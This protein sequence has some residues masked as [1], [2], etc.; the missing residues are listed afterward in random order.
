ML[1]TNFGN[2]R[3][4][5][6]ISIAGFNLLC[7]CNSVEA[8]IVG[9]RHTNT[10]IKVKDDISQIIGGRQAGNNLF[11]S[12][13]QFSVNSGTAASFEHG[14]DIDNIFSRVTGGNISQID[15]LIQTQG[16]ANLFLINPAG[17]IFGANARLDVGGSFIATTAERAIFE[18]GTK[19]SAATAENQPIL[20]ISSPIGLQYGRAAAVTVMPNADRGM[21][22]KNAGLSIQSGNTLGLLGGDV[23]I[24]RNSLNAIAGNIEIGSIKSGTVT[25]EPSVRGWNFNYDKVSE[26]GRINLSNRAFVNS[27]GVVN[28]RGKTIDF[29]SSSGISNFTDTSGGDGIVKLNAVRSVSLDSSFLFTQVG[30]ISSNIK[31]AISSAGGNISIEAPNI[32]LTSG[33]VISAGTLSEGA[34]GNI[35]LNGSQIIELSGG[36][37]NRP[38]IISTSTSGTGEGGDINLN[39][40]KLKIYDGSQIQAFAGEGKGGTII[41]KATESIDISGTGI[42]PIQDS[43]GKITKTILNSGFTA[44]S[45]FEDLPFE[46]QP[47]GES[48]NLIISAPKLTIADSGY[49]SVSNYGLKNAG[50]I[51]ITTNNLRLDTAGK[52]T[53]NTRSGEGGSIGIVARDLIMLDGKSSI[54]TSAGQNGNGGNIVLQADNLALLKQ[55]SIRANAERG[56]GGNVSIDTQGYFI[57]A[58]SEITASSQIETKE[59]TVEI[60]NPDFNSRLHTGQKE[61]KP[62]VAR[63]YISIGCGSREDI[64]QNHFQNVGRGGIPANPIEEITN[65]NV[66][67][68]LGENKRDRAVDSVSAKNT[69]FKVKAKADFTLKAKQNKL[70]NDKPLVDVYEPV[71]EANNWKINSQGK[72]ELI[73]RD[74]SSNLRNSSVCQIN[75]Q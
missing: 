15:G 18:D 30:Q 65:L 42:L 13:K 44:S 22:D 54:S 10:Q 12:F 8:Q 66:L 34:G 14:L 19:F 72:I 1:S 17:I 35:T 56:S 47:Q 31:E 62:L 27:S 20:T 37:K 6:S 48:G 63:D 26:Y 52:I 71:S 55:N 21:D 61:Y 39:I 70:N 75:K 28:F 11:H 9:D 49:I 40:S 3:L 7:S 5:I 43:T 16:K 68:D 51:E 41:A 53:A 24:T 46:R 57:S 64:V 36:I 29:A 58:D 25:L 69:F 50:D 32:F 74:S 45:G 33:S 2:S 38:S 67:E 73:A 4:K 59:G 60:I 23:S